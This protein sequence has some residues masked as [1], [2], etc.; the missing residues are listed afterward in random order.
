MSKRKTLLTI[1]FALADIALALHTKRRKRKDDGQTNKH[2]DLTI[3]R[4]P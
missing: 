3:G 1:I 4:N 2:N